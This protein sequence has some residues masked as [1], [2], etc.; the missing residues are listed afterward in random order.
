M[1][2][3]LAEAGRRAEFER[4]VADRTAELGLAQNEVAL[5]NEAKTSLLAAATATGAEL[6][7]VLDSVPAGIWIALPRWTTPQ[8]AP[9]C[10][11]RASTLTSRTASR[12][13]K[14]CEPVSSGFAAYSNMQAPLSPSRIS[15]AV[16]NPATQP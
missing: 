7:A 12:P 1:R 5:A 13:G 4:L 8:T 6:Q 2:L 11:C 14:R 3:R 10:E 9:L 16:F 15:M